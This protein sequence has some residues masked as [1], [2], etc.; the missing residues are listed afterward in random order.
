MT[1]L[2]E[3]WPQTPCPFGYIGTRPKNARNK[4]WWYAYE[5]PN[6]VGKVICIPCERII[7]GGINCLK[8]H[9]AGIKK[10]D[11]NPCLKVTK[12]EKRFI[13]AL[14]AAAKEKKIE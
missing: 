3:E 9:L 12:E 13:N 2:Q 7:S 6:D 5:A 8:Y 10:H 4:A 14:L 1:N 11:S